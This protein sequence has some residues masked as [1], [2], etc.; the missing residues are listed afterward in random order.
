[1]EA[2]FSF[3]G[4]WQRTRRNVFE[5]ERLR[6]ENFG[7]YVSARYKTFYITLLFL[8]PVQTWDD[9]VTWCYSLFNLSMI[10]LC[11]WLLIMMFV[12]MACSYLLWTF[13]FRFMF[14]FFS[15]IHPF[16]P[17]CTRRLLSHLINVLCWNFVLLHAFTIVNERTRSC[18]STNLC[19]KVHRSLD[20]SCQQILKTLQKEW[21]HVKCSC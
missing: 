1:M 17:F 5:S 16:I 14:P 4:W 15:S 10:F 3:R 12:T 21:W 7:S 11:F 2:V 19:N 9:D 8:S 18:P 13:F 6:Y 20:C